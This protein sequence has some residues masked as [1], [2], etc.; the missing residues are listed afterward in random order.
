MAKLFYPAI[1]EKGDNTYGVSF[2]NLPGCVSAGS[3][4]E[5]ALVNAHEALAG[6][7][8]LM[9]QDGDPLPKPSPVDAVVADPEINLVAV[10]LVGVTLPGRAKRVNV[11]L[12]E[13]L[14]DEIDAASENRSRFLSDAARAELARRSAG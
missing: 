7:V 13:A 14:L 11:T 8:A 5:E 9:V 4:A 12:D 1:L 6:H 2:P 3:T 10:S